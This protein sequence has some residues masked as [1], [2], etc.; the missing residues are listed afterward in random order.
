MELVN[1]PIQTRNNIAS[2]KC[3]QPPLCRHFLELD[4]ASA[5]H[6]AAH[7]GRKT[8]GGIAI[9][10]L[11]S[12]LAHHLAPVLG[13]E[14]AQPAEAPASVHGAPVSIKVAVGPCSIKWID[15]RGFTVGG[16]NN[17]H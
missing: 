6:L 5:E 15:A 17:A 11:G 7:Q 9:R 16:G 13:H 2:C 3:H 8:M 1:D 10:A 4:D 14:P 12:S